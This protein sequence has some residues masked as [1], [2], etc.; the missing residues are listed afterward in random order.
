MTAIALLWHF[1]AG[2]EVRERAGRMLSAL[3]PY[4][5]HHQALWS[6]G[7]VA[8]GRTLYRTT[9]ED[10]FD[11]QPV[12]VAGGTATIVAD[13]RLDNRDELIGDLGLA[14]RD[15]AAMADSEILAIAWERWEDACLPR[16]LG[17]FAFIVWDGRNQ[18]VFCA[19]DPL[20]HRPLFYHQ[21]AG[22]VAIASM[23][24]GLLA[25]PDVPKVLDED[26]L[27]AFVAALPVAGTDNPFG[28]LSFYRGIERL[29]P[30]NSL[31]ITR[32]QAVARP[33]WSAESVPAV[34][35]K[36]DDDYLQ[37]A[38]ELFD[39]AVAVRLRSTGA[40]GS[41]LSAGLDS[42]SVTVT[43][44]RLL[45]ARGERLTAFTAV[46]RPG[47]AATI[48]PHR[49]ADE[50]P[51]A[52]E[53]TSRFANIDHVLSPY[54]LVSPL[55]P[56]ERSLFA[57]DEPLRGL[58]NQAWSDD[59]G[60]RAQALRIRT[61]LY[62]PLGNATISYNGHE[63][64]Q[65]LL[66]KG[67]LPGWLGEMVHFAHR[68]SNPWSQIRLQLAASVSGAIHRDV[69]RA[70]GKW[71]TR[72]DR[73]SPLSSGSIADLDERASPRLRG[74]S[75]ARLARDTRVRIIAYADPGTFMAG[76]LA[77]FGL[78]M[79]DP[80]ADRRL[81][82]FCLGIP[83]DQFYRHGEDR[84]LVR[85]MMRDQLP[86]GVLYS[87]GKGMQGVGWLRNMYLGRADLLAEVRAA[88][89]SAL[90]ARLLDLDGLE[91]LALSVP[92]GAP[93]SLADVANYRQKLLRGAAAARF[94]RHV[95][96]GNVA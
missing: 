66:S 76:D 21:G 15:A 45:A 5:P 59:I 24:K 42:S 29:P 23:P 43:A 6:D 16:L 12:R 88:R 50:G 20:G 63:R 62:A 68:G 25:L 90:G 19:R 81:L 7:P 92:D 93:T 38:H 80:T 46:P 78:D 30:A 40:I 36:T 22:F 37:R 77:R 8:L 96:G 28:G 1:D 73:R 67:D 65:E 2:G 52:A 34:R 60:R 18:R 3:G 4:G 87:Q 39:R 71:W 57:L 47:E 27:G 74:W 82:E 35:Y 32:G 54:P 72:L 70:G 86:A 11:H 83:L 75:D 48:M 51:L 84:R 13:A 41:Q 69:L 49:F 53:T 94:I 95:E 89:G 14:P 10:A 56:M 44:A 31:T 55:E 79:R 33:Y 9:P 17:D 64:F 58:C 85:R 61:L 26:L 91:K